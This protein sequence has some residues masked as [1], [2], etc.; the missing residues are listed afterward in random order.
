[1][2]KSADEKIEMSYRILGDG[3]NWTIQDIIDIGSSKTQVRTSEDT[4]WREKISQSVEFLESMWQKEKVIYG[5]TTGY[6]GSCNVRIPPH[7]VEELPSQL[8]KFHGC[9]LGDFLTGE[10]NSRSTSRKTCFLS[11]WILR[12]SA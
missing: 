5:V 9:G 4:K 3:R 11:Q 2:S 10:A 12:G 6:G 1:M 8:T 7:L